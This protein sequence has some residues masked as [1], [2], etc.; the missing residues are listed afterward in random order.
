MVLPGD[1][2]LGLDPGKGAGEMATIS[3]EGRR[4]INYLMIIFRGSDKIY[5]CW[6]CID[7]AVKMRTKLNSLRED[8]LEEKSG[9]NSHGNTSSNNVCEVTVAKRCRV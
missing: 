6:A 7:L 2:Q 4:H 5:Q 1:R 8:Q 3:K 9:A